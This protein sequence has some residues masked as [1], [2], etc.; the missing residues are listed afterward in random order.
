MHE[1]GSRVA[2]AALGVL[3]AVSSAHAA[4]SQT[5]KEQ[6]LRYLAA[7]DRV[8]LGV[9][10]AAAR[11]TR[12]IE[13]RVGACADEAP[14]AAQGELTWLPVRF[15]FL[16]TQKLLVPRY[17]RFARAV[18]TTRPRDPTLVRFASFI[19]RLARQDARLSRLGLDYC[20]FLTDWR[21]AGWT[22]GYAD[23]WLARSLRA[24]GVDARLVRRLDARLEALAP[25]LRRIGLSRSQADRLV[26]ETQLFI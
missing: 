13:A 21:D 1:L 12:T 5:P 25:A 16:L 15:E 2:V 6:A 3:L 17:Q 4:P 24:A 8:G 26:V 23:V 11:A 19:G 20:R 7:A 22:A 18:A 10:R 14:P 9:E